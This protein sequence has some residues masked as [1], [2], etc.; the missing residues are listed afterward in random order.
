L[1]VGLI[2]FAVNFAVKVIDER[3]VSAMTYHVS[4]GT[5][6]VTHS[7]THSARTRT[8][9]ITCSCSHAWSNERQ[10]K[11]ANWAWIKYVNPIRYNTTQ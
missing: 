1:Y 5:L 9:F 2:D 11:Y 7:L 6:N 4:R 10:C 3:T 8:A